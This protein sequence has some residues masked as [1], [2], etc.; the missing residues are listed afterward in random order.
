[1]TETEIVLKEVIKYHKY[2]IKVS[3]DCIPYYRKEMQYDKLIEIS[4]ELKFHKCC[5]LTIDNLMKKTK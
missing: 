1:M 2:R 4:H 5:L 3:K